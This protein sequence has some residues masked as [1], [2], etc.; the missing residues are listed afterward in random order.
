MTAMLKVT[1]LPSVAGG[2]GHISRTASL[3]RA[4]RQL[5]PGVGVDYVLDSDRLRP[6]N[7]EA[8]ERMGF[9][10][11]LLPPRTRQTRDAIIREF[12]GDT[13]VIVDDTARYLLP[14]RS[15][16]PRAAWVSIPLFPVGDELFMDWPFMAQMDAIIWAYAPVFGIPPELERFRDKLLHTGPFL[17]IDGIPDKA[18]ARAE[19]GIGG[20]EQAL[21]YAP[22]GFPFGI[23]FGHR[24]LSAVYAAIEGL[25]ATRFPRLRLILL[26]VSQPQELHG[27]VG[28]PEQLPPWVET[29]GVIKP[30]QAL[31]FEQAADIVVAEGTSTM[32]ECAALRTPLLIIP[33]TIA[34]TQILG[35]RLSEHRAATRVPIEYVTPE[36]IAAAIEF[37]LA[38]HE[39]RAAT[40]ARAHQ[41]VTKGGGAHAAAERVLEIAATRSHSRAAAAMP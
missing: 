40:T 20:A 23:E 5:E 31:R 7:I 26:A 6:F 1:M 39:A 28:V 36:S 22:R 27:V 24:V 35:E 34:E 29:H 15:I 4:L 41:L 19:L 16:V 9:P 2:I 18:A 30:E 33:G 14:L 17:Q 37:I 12:F 38:D 13:D 25:R 10:A 32:H 11:R 8:T 3:A 21:V